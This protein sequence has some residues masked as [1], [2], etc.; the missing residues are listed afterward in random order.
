MI[1][2]NKYLGIPVFFLILFLMFIV[3]FGP[4]GEGLKGWVEMLIN[5]VLAENLL[6]APVSYTHLDEIARDD[7]LHTVNGHRINP[8]QIDQRDFMLLNLKGS[9]FFL[10]CV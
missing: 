2:T 1:V 8:R 5:D 4:I 10:R 3:T 6:A 9:F 7:F